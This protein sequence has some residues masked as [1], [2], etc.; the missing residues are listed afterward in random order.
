MVGEQRAARQGTR[1]ANARATP[2]GS[3][4]TRRSTAGGA[5][6]GAGP[7]RCPC[8]SGAGS[9]PFGAVSRIRRPRDATFHADLDVLLTAPLYKSH[10]WGWLHGDRTTPRGVRRLDPAPGQGERITGAGPTPMDS[11]EHHSTAIL[12]SGSSGTPE[13]AP[14]AVRPDI[15]MM[16]IAGKKGHTRQQLPLPL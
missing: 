16:M 7:P 9:L 10:V 6:R 3:A 2:A 12:H 8:R 5:H 4:A 1:A 11:A 14:A 13:G 15:V